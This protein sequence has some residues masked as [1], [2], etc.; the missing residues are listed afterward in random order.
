[1]QKKLAAIANIP[2]VIQ[3]A[4]EEVA[5]VLEKFVPPEPEVVEPSDDESDYAVTVESLFDESEVMDVISQADWDEDEPVDSNDEEGEPE[6][7]E[8]E[9]QRIEKMQRVEKLEKCWP[10][11]DQAKPVHK[12]SNYTLSSSHDIIEKRY[13]MK[14]YFLW[15]LT[16]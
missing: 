8:E 14:F 11:G 9:K 13:G 12:I 3:M 10:W 5:K 4:I 7:T 2:S 16:K 1:M 15:I 6:I